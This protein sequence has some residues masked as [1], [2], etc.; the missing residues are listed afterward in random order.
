[1]GLTFR[2]ILPTILASV[3][4]TVA[5]LASLMP[6]A[7]LGIMLIETYPG[8]YP[9]EVVPGIAAW[10]A[11]L[12]WFVFALGR[13][14]YPR[15]GHDKRFLKKLNRRLEAERVRVVY[16]TAGLPLRHKAFELLDA[17]GRSLRRKMSWEDVLALGKQTSKV[18]LAD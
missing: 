15:L 5:I 18:A 7:A 1:M 4:Q 14:W 9:F 6:G 12:Y 16:V 2:S 3:F 17:D 8:K 10:L 13:G 11:I